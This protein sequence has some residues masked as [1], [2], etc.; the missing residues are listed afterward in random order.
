MLRGGITLIGL[1][2]LNYVARD[3]QPLARLIDDNYIASVTLLDTLL[4][5][6]AVSLYPSN[7][8]LPSFSDCISLALINTYQC[9]AKRNRGRWETGLTPGPLAKRVGYAL[10]NE[11]ALYGVSG[12]LLYNYLN[13]NRESK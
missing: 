1:F 12:V 3:G 6:Y 11:Y 5:Q 13:T 2:L 4:Y 9:I 7:R 8:Y 10:D